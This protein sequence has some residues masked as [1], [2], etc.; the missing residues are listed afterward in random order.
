M[1]ELKHKVSV[2]RILRRCPVR[3]TTVIVN[4]KSLMVTGDSDGDGNVYGDGSGDSIG[5]ISDTDD[6]M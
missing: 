3:V 4:M 2:L 1:G 5:H 6:S